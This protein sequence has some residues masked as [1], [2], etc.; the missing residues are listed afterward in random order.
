MTATGHIRKRGESFQVVVERPTTTPA[1][2]RRSYKAG[3]GSKKQAEGVLRQLLQEIEG[4]SYIRPSKITVAEWIHQWLNLY[5][6]GSRSVTTVEGYRNQIEKYIIPTLGDIFLQDLSPSMVQRWINDLR[7]KSPRSGKPLSPKTIRNIWLNLSTAMEKAVMEE[8]VKKNPCEYTELPP[9]EKY[10]A[11]VYDSKEIQLLLEAAHGTDME[12]PMLIE[13]CLGLRRGELLA[14][15]WKHIDFEH[16]KV[17]ICENLVEVEKILYTKSPKTRSGI[18]TMEIPQTLRMRLLQERKRYLERKLKYGADF[19]DEDYVICQ[20]N[21]KPYKP[22]SMGLKFR[23]FLQANGLKQIRFHDLRH[24]NATLMLT[25]GISP[26]VAQQRLGH[27]DFSTT[28]NIYSH[29]LE[30]VDKEAANAIDQAIFGN[31]RFA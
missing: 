12:L 31:T 14:L 11:Q 3:N 2:R 25:N 29:V 13:I 18:R 30:S 22:D 23:R 9:R 17:T 28:M 4:Q 16:S 24:T 15:K 27:S 7:E 20:E 1:Q 5:I 10:E 8:L 19:Y 21:G 26:K 6:E